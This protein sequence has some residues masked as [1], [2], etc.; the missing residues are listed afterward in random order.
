MM[1]IFNL[2]DV[3]KGYT[4]WLTV[5]YSLWIDGIIGPYFF[6]NENDTVNEETYHNR[7]FV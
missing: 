1:L 4:H 5:K 6:E 3:L 7:F 2:L